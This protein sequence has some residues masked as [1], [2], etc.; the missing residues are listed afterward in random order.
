MGKISGLPEKERLAIIGYL[1][2]EG[3]VDT[4]TAE[5]PKRKIAEFKEE[6]GVEPYTIYSDQKYGNQFRI[7]LTDP[8]SA[9]PA[10]KAA[11]DTRYS[12]LN[13]TKFIKELIDSY[14]FSF[15]SKQNSQNILERAKLLDSDSYRAFLQG[16]NTNN[17]FID[18][19]T[20]TVHGGD[21]PI[22]TITSVP[23]EQETSARKK[24]PQKAI[25]DSNVLF[26]EE[27][28]LHLGWA[29]EEYLYKFLETRTA[30]AF[31]PFAIDARNVQDIVWYNLG[32]ATSEKWTD[33]S[34][35]KGGD[36]LVKTIDSEY[37]IEVKSSR[38]QSPIFGMT[39]L[40]MQK[41]MEYRNRYYLAKLDYL[42]NLVFGQA[43]SLRVFR[44]PYK[45]FFNPTRMQ[46]ATF[47]C[48]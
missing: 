44:D 30:A 1:A 3:V 31:V 17:D 15:F 28:L 6:Y 34:I 43:P 2:Q 8:E 39:S 22:P 47:F 33:G 11:L 20:N 4:I 14:G 7:Y 38:R 9:P 16:Y 26:S 27:Q 18:T 36:I 35:G 40:E 13:D 46:R 48:N 21:L 24:K 32:Y 25:P 29:G 23:D 12:R 45:R 19:L 37:L 10:L 5:V 41:M 42:E